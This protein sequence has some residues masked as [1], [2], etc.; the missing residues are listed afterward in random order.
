VDTQNQGTLI[1]HGGLGVMLSGIQTPV[2][3]F[4]KMARSWWRLKSVA[5]LGR[6]SAE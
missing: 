6:V 4:I 1:V 5:A 2:A 3:L